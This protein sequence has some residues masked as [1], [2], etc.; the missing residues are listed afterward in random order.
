MFPKR[1][2]ISVYEYIYSLY[3]KTAASAAGAVEVKYHGV[4]DSSVTSQ[5]M[6]LC[7]SAGCTPLCV[8]VCVCVSE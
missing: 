7:G 4:L 1:R 5:T 2:K 8:N 6:V 3:I